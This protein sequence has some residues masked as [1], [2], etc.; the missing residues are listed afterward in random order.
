MKLILKI[1]L[2]LIIFNLGLYSQDNKKNDGILCHLYVQNI[3]SSCL[4]LGSFF[5]G[6]SELL[7][8]QNLTFCVEGSGNQNINWEITKTN[9][10]N[11]TLQT[12]YYVSPDGRNWTEK[13]S[14]QGRVKL[15][16]WGKYYFRI[17]INQV[18]IASGCQRGD[19]QCRYTLSVEYD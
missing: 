11:F 16:R 19:Y 7:N 12:K 14:T 8:N 9:N 1:I 4:F 2:M 13:S 10:S 3:N 17:E 5:P 15:N 18:A 6:F